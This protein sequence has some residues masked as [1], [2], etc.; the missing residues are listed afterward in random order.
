MSATCTRLGWEDGDVIEDLD[1]VSNGGF[2][3]VC[4]HEM[5]YFQDPLKE[6]DDIPVVADTTEVDDMM[7][8]LEVGDTYSSGVRTQ[9]VYVYL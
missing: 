3:P 5:E 7:K 8:S 4:D 2:V 6:S 1:N 9:C